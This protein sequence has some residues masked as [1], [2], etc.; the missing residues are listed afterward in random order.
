MPNNI[1]VVVE[2]SEG[3]FQVT[4]TED[5][6]RYYP[7]ARIEGV[8]ISP[9][10]HLV[11]ILSILKKL[12]LTSLCLERD[13]SED[14]FK[15]LKLSK[16]NHSQD[17]HINELLSA[18]DRELFPID[19]GKRGDLTHSG[20]HQVLRACWE[21]ELLS[22]SLSKEGFSIAKI[23]A[24]MFD[25]VYGKGL[26]DFHAERFAFHS[27]HALRVFQ[28]LYYKDQEDAKAGIESV[29]ASS[30]DLKVQGDDYK[31]VVEHCTHALIKFSDLF[32]AISVRSQFSAAAA[33]DLPAIPA[34]VNPLDFLATAKARVKATEQAVSDAEK[35]V[36]AAEAKFEQD[37]KAASKVAVDTITAAPEAN[38]HEVSV[39]AWAAF[40]KTR[41][42]LIQTKWVVIDALEAARKARDEAHRAEPKV[43]EAAFI[44][45]YRQRIAEAKLSEEK[46]AIIDRMVAHREAKKTNSLDDTDGNHKETPS[47]PATD[48]LTAISKQ[49]DLLKHHSGV[50]Y[51]KHDRIC[52]YSLDKASSTLVLSKEFVFTDKT[53]L[54]Q[55]EITI[56][57]FVA[58]REAN[59]VSASGS[60]QPEST[61]QRLIR[62]YPFLRAFPWQTLPPAAF[63]LIVQI[64]EGLGLNRPAVKSEAGSVSISEPLQERLL[65]RLYSLRTL[66]NEPTLAAMGAMSVG[67]D[68]LEFSD[69][70]TAIEQMPGLMRSHVLS[71]SDFAPALASASPSADRKM[72][73]EVLVATIM[74]IRKPA[75]RAQPADESTSIRTNARAQV[76]HRIEA[77]KVLINITLPHELPMVIELL[78]AGFRGEFVGE[79][80]HA[81]RFEEVFKVLRLIIPK[82]TEANSKEV[83]D[84]MIPL[85]TK[86]LQDCWHND[87][88]INLV[89][90]LD[91]LPFTSPH[92]KMVRDAVIAALIRD[93]KKGLATETDEKAK[94]DRVEK[95]SQA[96]AKAQSDRVKKTPETDAKE[97]A[98]SDAKFEH[99]RIRSDSLRCLSA[100]VKL[101][102][103]K[104]DVLPKEVLQNIMILIADHSTEESLISADG[105][106]ANLT[107]I[108]SEL[109]RIITTRILTQ[110][111]K[112]ESYPHYSIRSEIL[113]DLVFFA[114]DPA[115]KSE[116]IDELLFVLEKCEIHSVF[117]CLH[118]MLKLSAPSELKEMKERIGVILEKRKPVEYYGKGHGELEKAFIVHLSQTSMTQAKP[119][120]SVADIK[121]LMD[122]V[123]ND[124]AK[125][126]DR[127]Q[128]AQDLISIFHDNP[129]A[130]EAKGLSEWLLTACKT[131][132][133]DRNKTRMLKVVGCLPLDSAQ[134]REFLPAFISSVCPF[135]YD[136]DFA[137]VVTAC[138]KNRRLSSEEI[139]FTLEL[140]TPHIEQERHISN[141][142]IPNIIEALPIQPEHTP[143]FIKFVN[144]LFETG[145][146]WNVESFIAKKLDPKTAAETM[147]QQFKTT[148]GKVQAGYLKALGSLRLTSEQYRLYFAVLLS[149]LK[150]KSPDSSHDLSWAV[151]NFLREQQLSSEDLKFTLDTFLPYITEEGEW[152]TWIHRV[153]EGLQIPPTH[154][155]MFM[156][157]VGL[158]LIKAGHQLEVLLL[159]KFSQIEPK[160][161][162]EATAIAV[163]NALITS[164]RI[165][166]QNRTL[167]L[168]G[169]FGIPDPC[170][171]YLKSA[172]CTF[173][174]EQP[175]RL[176][177]FQ[178]FYEARQDREHDKTRAVQNI[179][180]GTLL[181]LHMIFKYRL[182][183]HE[184]E[185]AIKA[186]F[187]LLKEDDLEQ[188]NEIIQL[189][190]KIEIPFGCEQCVVEGLTP[191]LSLKG[192]GQGGLKLM[193]QKVL[194]KL[195]Q[196]TRLQANLAETLDL[197]RDRVQ[198]QQQLAPV[199]C[200]GAVIASVSSATPRPASTTPNATTAG[201]FPV[202]S[203]AAAAAAI[204]AE[205]NRGHEEKT[206]A[207]K[208]PGPSVDA[209][210]AAS[211]AAAT[212]TPDPRSAAMN[213][214]V[215]A[216][217]VQAAVDVPRT[218]EL[219]AIYERLQP[220]LRECKARE[221]RRRDEESAQKEAERVRKDQARRDRDAAAKAA[222]APA[223]AIAPAS[224]GA[225]ASAAPANS[226]ASVLT[227]SP[228]AGAAVAAHAGA[229]ATPAAADHFTTAEPAGKSRTVGSHG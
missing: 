186:M 70:L 64:F 111:K 101:Y 75:N 149:T 49:S 100:F 35:A 43:A 215:T 226:P 158:R 14:L 95:G 160:S 224:T 173:L 102:H 174:S 78:A 99:S 165:Y 97:K 30:A 195:G 59:E 50:I 172:L 129:A 157:D 87:H 37:E 170:I 69:D 89:E 148:K 74:G 169:H 201:A 164:F 96:D 6:S 25:L 115:V 212:V 206:K 16:P 114:R 109:Q 175:R 92:K 27:S 105:I 67:G 223:S 138:F 46:L 203:A 13:L 1:L 147:W 28:A 98:D 141:S 66:F 17:A 177:D 58:G 51:L 168:L 121:T 142:W 65:E 103:N 52:F 181:A 126:T 19:N 197:E 33:A 48:I 132:T 20:F 139:K 110:I 162:E 184:A 7:V 198:R 135:Y 179:N 156:A 93:A 199:A 82:I 145:G 83:L 72:V 86:R 144:K 21:T 125:E 137:K 191:L 210:A 73:L 60:A 154:S 117:T 29:A 163:T 178:R 2:A 220:S 85:I 155:N 136:R 107:S 80:E 113:D 193:A 31:A 176:A 123:L 205:L 15:E 131:E 133:I 143:D 189:F 12:N 146:W 84:K 118:H 116:V 36:D 5:S 54:L 207:D 202:G 228:A 22:K 185:P 81:N 187:L 26:G 9:Q 79:R 24:P 56:A 124:E 196:T 34:G 190:L 91:E 90:A 47:V 128:A 45:L 183:S 41:H 119:Q 150:E 127:D 166:G 68:E 227:F 194:L 44:A 214:S 120:K 77:L 40:D 152:T 94:S 88:T 221:M 63:T 222:P 208:T 161:I 39:Q 3:N 217:V 134:Y 32:E 180:Q 216:G 153:V 225:A 57:T 182:N 188:R 211:A 42:D 122:T 140:I 151:E 192:P 130:P 71:A 104:P 76:D 200:V 218:N 159:D 219:Q 204:V 167:T 18:L 10:P 53:N 11:N 213:V 229:S 106:T 23:F 108:P 209:I 38:R 61:I 171:A 8:E 55:L 62:Q 4:S 112:Q